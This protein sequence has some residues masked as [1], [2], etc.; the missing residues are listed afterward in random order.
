MYVSKECLKSLFAVQG[1][2]HCTCKK[3][4]IFSS[5]HRLLAEA[6]GEFPEIAGL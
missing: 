5:H 6:S 4:G 1:D 2:E 3:R